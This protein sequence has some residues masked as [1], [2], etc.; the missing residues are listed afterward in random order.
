MTACIA[1][2]CG[3]FKCHCSCTPVKTPPPIAQLVAASD[4]GSPRSQ[5]HIFNRCRCRSLLLN[6]QLAAQLAR[7]QLIAI[8][9]AP[10]AR[11]QAGTEHD[12]RDVC[13]T[14][15]HF[16]KKEKDA[17]SQ[18]MGQTATTSATSPTQSR[19]SGLRRCAHCRCA[20]GVVQHCRNVC[21]M[22]LSG[23]AA[24]SP[25]SRVKSC[26][27]H[28][29]CSWSTL[30]CQAAPASLFTC[31]AADQDVQQH[32]TDGLHYGDSHVPCRF[33]L[34]PSSKHF[35][36]CAAGTKWR[37]LWAHLQAQRGAKLAKRQ[38]VLWRL[39]EVALSPQGLQRR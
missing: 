10:C 37:Q 22:L 34:T 35:P 31:T 19:G 12:G 14:Q 16:K 8:R 18:A 4:L 6:S 23:Q 38:P 32:G 36:D 1:L 21:Q 28:R 27:D 24:S 15:A 3:R 2:P 11:D 29:S 17:F 26:W 25:A 9:P 5:L 7:P 39:P 13:R 33:L 30:G 20:I